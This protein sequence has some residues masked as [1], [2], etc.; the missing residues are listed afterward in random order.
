M[1]E[2]KQP[3]FIAMLE[4][5]LRKIEEEKPNDRSEKDRKYA[6][7]KTDLEK[8]IAYCDYFLW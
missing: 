1:E 8:L 3:E 7:A 6:I 4:E 2:A 5:A